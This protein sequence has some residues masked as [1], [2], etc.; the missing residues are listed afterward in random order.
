MK[1]FTN[2]IL[3]YINIGSNPSLISM[4]DDG[5]PE[6]IDFLRDLD[7]K[8]TEVDY[9]FCSLSYQF[10]EGLSTQHIEKEINH[11]LEISNYPLDSLT[12]A[13]KNKKTVVVLM[14]DLDLLEDFGDAANA[15]DALLK[16]YRNQ[17]YFTYVL[18][19]PMMVERL[20]QAVWSYS[21]TQEV[22]MYNE[23]GKNWTL[24]ELVD[25]CKKQYKKEL[26]QDE[27][28]EIEKLSNKHFGL[29]KRLYRDRI[30]DQPQIDT[31]IESLLGDFSIEEIN[32]FKKLAL[33]KKMSNTE[34]K[35]RDAFQKVNFI[36]ME[37][38]ITIPI[39]A[40]KLKSYRIKG[41][42]SIDKSTDKL[43]GLDLDLLSRTERNIIEKLM[44]EGELIDKE[45]IGDLI[46]GDEVG[47]KYSEWAIDQRISR[48]KRK[49]R[50]LGFNVDIKTVYGKGYSLVILD[51]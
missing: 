47:D 9:Y 14:D 2:K 23:V 12:E 28:A 24:D 19:H 29:F 36:D 11:Q 30:L 49:L 13:V 46:W 17:I 50:D 33:N 7:P 31:Y 43:S 25:I 32:T 22:F 51:D 1:D 35:I 16:K 27:I 38:N 37:G 4:A 10:L 48:L 20:Q 26:T 8:E 18:E 45:E 3:E 42:I 21:S 41:K 44:I 6:I 34:T 5:L 15:T 40:E 39:I